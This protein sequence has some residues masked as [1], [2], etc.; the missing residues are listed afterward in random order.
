[1]TKTPDQCELCRR[2]PVVTTV[3][4]LTPREEGGS[5][6]PTADLC[7]ACHQHIHHLFTNRQ[8]VELQLTT[9][10]ALQSNPQMASFL[11]WIRKQPASTIPR[12]RKS[13]NVRQSRK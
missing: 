8:L 13:A 9:I 12:S 7:V 5:F 2:T 11:K 1:M 3:H 10:E 4:H 6:L